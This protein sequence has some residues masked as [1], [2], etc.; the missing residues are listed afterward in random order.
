MT[1]VSVRSRE[2]EDED[3]DDVK[4][5]KQI[6]FATLLSAGVMVSIDLPKMQEA[7]FRY[8]SPAARNTFKRPESPVTCA[9]T[10]TSICE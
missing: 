10:R 8:T 9:S 3:E 6:V 2:E 4:I 5:P 1:N 7:M